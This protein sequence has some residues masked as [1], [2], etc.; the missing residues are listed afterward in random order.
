MLNLWK[1]INFVI[2]KMFKIDFIK[3]WVYNCLKEKIWINGI[4]MV[5]TTCFTFRAQINHMWF[6]K[7][8]KVSEFCVLIIT[9]DGCKHGKV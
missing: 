9:F 2:K 6:L 5:Y 7:E 4:F 1:T 8:F 3:L